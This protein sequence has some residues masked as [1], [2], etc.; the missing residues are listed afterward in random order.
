MCCVTE[1][2]DKGSYRYS[3]YLSLS[4]D[5]AKKSRRIFEIEEWRK[6]RGAD[7]INLFYLRSLFL[8]GRKGMMGKIS[9]WQAGE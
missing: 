2:Q 5:Q 9:Q 7:K 8:L 1:G 3:P 4:R 6:G